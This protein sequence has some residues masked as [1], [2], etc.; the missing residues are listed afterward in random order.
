MLTERLQGLGLVLFGLL[1]MSLVYLIYQ[2]GGP[3]GGP[4][5]PPAPPGLKG[6]NP[7]PL[8]SATACFLPLLALTSMG[9]I[10]VGLRRIVDPS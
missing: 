1:G 4:S 7:Q 6:L 3:L 5:P 2:N 9:L 10:L 8:I